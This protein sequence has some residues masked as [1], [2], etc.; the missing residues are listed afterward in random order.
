MLGGQVSSIFDG[1]LRDARL[2]YTAALVFFALALGLRFALQPVLGTLG[3]FSFFLL[4]VTAASLTGGLGPGM[5]VTAL[6]GVAAVYFFTPTHTA[7]LMGPLLVYIAIGIGISGIG[8]LH[9]KRTA[10]LLDSQRRLNKIAIESTRRVSETDE[11]LSTLSHELRT[12]L[13][14]ILGWVHLM[15]ETSPRSVT[16]MEH[17]IAVIERNARAQAQIVDDLLDMSRIVA[18]RMRLETGAVSLP[19]LVAGVVE[20]M[21]PAFDAKGLELLREIDPEVSPISGDPVRLRQ[22]VA[23]LL[24]N[25]LKFTPA[26]GRVMVALTRQDG[27]A[28]IVVSDT[29]QGIH[30]AFLPHVFEHF[31]QAD[32]SARRAHGGLGIGLALVKSLAELHGGHV[33]ASS[34]GENGGAEF[35]VGLPLPELIGAAAPGLP[36]M[37]RQ[38]P[39]PQMWADRH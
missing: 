38:R 31:R 36:T 30:S 2:R 28:R 10:D 21:T 25:A 39:A 33:S 32:Q 16:E 5:L 35:V 19:R 4:A 23:N 29:G 26:G 27:E 24:S 11:F 34:P 17:G 37:A 3:P 18:G 12:P 1:G 22:V 15:Q 9:R 7:G 20:E 6:G 14:A 13:N 8:G